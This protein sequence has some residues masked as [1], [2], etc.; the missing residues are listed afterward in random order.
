MKGRRSACFVTLGDLE[1]ACDYDYDAPV[2]GDEQGIDPPVPASVSN[3]TIEL[4]SSDVTDYLADA[5]IDRIVERIL[6]IEQ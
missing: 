5:I 6:E 2:E 3:L 1:F 4:G